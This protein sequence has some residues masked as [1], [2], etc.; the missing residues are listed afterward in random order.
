MKLNLDK[1]KEVL[2]LLQEDTITPK[3]A[4]ELVDLLV[5]LTEKQKQDLMSKNE[6]FLS[7]V[8]QKTFT[9]IQ[10]ALIEIKEKANDNQL[11]VRQLTNK[12]RI[13]H[14]A[15]MAQL[16]ALIEEFR[17]FEIPEIDEER[18]I[19]DVLA[20][21]PQE[22]GDSVIKKINKSDKKIKKE[23]IEGGDKL[24]EQASLDRA[25]SI[26]D[27]RTQFLINKPSGSS[28][29]GSGIPAG[30]NKQLQFND[31]GLFGGADITYENG[32][33]LWFGPT[34]T[35]IRFLGNSTIY[36][37]VQSAVDQAGFQLTLDA[38]DGNGVG[39]GGIGAVRGGSGGAE[40]V[41]GDAFIQAGQGGNASADG[42]GAGGNTFMYSGSAQFGNN[43]GG[44]IG[45]VLG[46]ASGTGTHGLLKISGGVQSAL[47]NV[48]TI[49]NVNLTANRNY[50]LPDA[51][52]TIAM[53]VNGNT[54]DMNG[55][56]TLT[57]PS[58]GLDQAQ[59]LTLGLGA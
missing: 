30:S 26:L 6:D 45:L 3:Q 13:S 27:Q 8:S 19:Q 55:E 44:N 31:S 39:S 11:E 41:G 22:T 53:S 36:G 49:D 58:S 12:Q 40:G 35:Q 46:T 47:G 9:Q 10:N 29:G 37:G 1:A 32:S 2:Q 14:E 42:S 28:S 57:I 56:I 52:G 48:A 7:Q 20:Q 25:I 51:D 4:K 17:A 16:G 21:V 43:D 50:N 23:R 33:G 5:Q 38:G 24:V 18:I 15:K 54:A 34:A 59:V